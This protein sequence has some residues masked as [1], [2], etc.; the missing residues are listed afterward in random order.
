MRVSRTTCALLLI[1]T[2]GGMAELRLGEQAFASEDIHVLFAVYYLENG[3]PFGS[4]DYGFRVTAPFCRNQRQ[5]MLDG[6]LDRGAEPRGAT[7]AWLPDQ[8]MLVRLFCLPLLEFEN[9]SVRRSLVS[10]P[11]EPD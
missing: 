7:A 1:A 11:F 10:D 5:V 8:Q 2:I 3:H 9:P 6:W 4:A